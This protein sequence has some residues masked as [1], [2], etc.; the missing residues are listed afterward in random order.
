MQEIG[1]ECSSS[2]DCGDGTDQ[3]SI[4]DQQSPGGYC[5]ELGCDWNTC[6]DEAVCV[7]FYRRRSRTSRA[8]WRPRT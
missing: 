1:D 7:R 3:T 4:C 8:C 2:L 6:P 5:T